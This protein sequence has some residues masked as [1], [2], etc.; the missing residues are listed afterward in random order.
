MLSSIAEG[1]GSVC[2][3]LL[4]AQYLSVGASPLLYMVMWQAAAMVLSPPPSPS[5]MIYTV[6]DEWLKAANA[7]Y[8]GV[9]MPLISDLRSGSDFTPF[10]QL[11]G[12]SSASMGYVSQW[13]FLKNSI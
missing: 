8:K 7:S 12:I 3:L 2:S 4:G 1:Q 13:S 10:L 5:G 6:Y 11:Q 9:L